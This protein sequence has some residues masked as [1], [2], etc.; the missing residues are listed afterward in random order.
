[1]RLRALLLCS[2]LASQ[3][4]GAQSISITP[5][6]GITLPISGRVVQRVPAPPISGL[7][8][9]SLVNEFEQG[10]TLGLAVDVDLG[11]RFG[12]AALLSLNAAERRSHQREIEGPGRSTEAHTVSFALLGTVRAHPTDRLLLRLSAG[13][14]LLSLSG[15]A[16]SNEG[17][18]LPPYYLAENRVVLG[19]LG[20]ASLAIDTRMATLSLGAAY[21]YY[22]PRFGTGPKGFVVEPSIVE[23]TAVSQLVLSLGVQLR[24]RG[25]ER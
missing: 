4:L 15:G 7:D 6:G 20:T 24:A 19:G 2:V 11:D 23:Q 5:F 21:R 17:D 14:E 1:M 8:S 12:A 9:T 10:Y 25:G 3:D 16:A 22:A 18:V 13:P